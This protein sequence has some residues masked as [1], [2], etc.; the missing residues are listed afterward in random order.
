MAGPALEI[1]LSTFQAFD[2]PIPI[3]KLVRV[4]EEKLGVK[5]MTF[6]KISISINGKR[7]IAADV[8]LDCQVHA[9]KSLIKTSDELSKKRAQ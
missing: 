6:S 2:C 7:A 3:N 5:I 1:T 4:F 8:N 9:T